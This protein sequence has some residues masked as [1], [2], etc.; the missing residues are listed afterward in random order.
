[1]TTFPVYFEIIISIHGDLDDK[2]LSSSRF[3]LIIFS[4]QFMNRGV[5]NPNLL[6]FVVLGIGHSF[7][8]WVSFGFGFGIWVLLRLW[9]YDNDYYKKYHAYGNRARQSTSR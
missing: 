4:S 9:N 3:E 1:M 6:G 8:F 7:G 2:I 5:P